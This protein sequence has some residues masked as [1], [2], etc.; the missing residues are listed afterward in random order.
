MPLSDY[1]SH[2]NMHL[3]KCFTLIKDTSAQGFSEWLIDVNE[4]KRYGTYMT[5]GASEFCEIKDK[6]CKT[7]EGC[8]QE[9]DAF[10]ELGTHPIFLDIGVAIL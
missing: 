10:E 1:E 7:K 4:N 8:K 5:I 6:P 9:W 3:K 2:Y